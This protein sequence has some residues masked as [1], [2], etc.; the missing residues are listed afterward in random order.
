MFQVVLTPAAS[1]RLIARA[2]VRH[3]DVARVLQTGTLVIVAGTTNA[4]VAEEV[5]A[6][7]GQLDGFDRRRFY[8][9]VTV[10][11][12][13]QAQFASPVQSS[14]FLGDVVI[15]DG[16]WLKGKT[17]FDVVDEL[18]PAD[19]ILKGANALD[20]DH[21]A[22]AVLIAHP[23]CGTS[24]AV[25]QAAVGKRTKLIVPIGLEKRVPGS[26]DRLVSVL[27]APAAQGPRLLP[28]P[29]E[30][31]TELDAIRLQT[32]AEAIPVAA[33]G[34]CGAE[35][36]VWLAVSGT[37]EQETAAKQFI[38]AVVHEPMFMV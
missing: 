6:Q 26:L 34:V 13:K 29:G 15:R 8:R 21:R 11:P 28:L 20:L 14:M 19:L 37:L 17:I 35:G 25:I 36:C 23:K 24:L 3:P 5:L 16:H 27:N 7:L 38:D 4:Y 18:G 12:T 10:P 9:G 31:F 33:G 32:G 30:V 1:K 22:A 2:I